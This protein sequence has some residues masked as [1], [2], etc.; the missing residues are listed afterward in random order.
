MFVLWPTGALHVNSHAV[1][2]MLEG[3]YVR[4]R[5]T[6]GETWCMFTAFSEV[7]DAPQDDPQ[8]ALQDAPQDSPQDGPQSGPHR[9]D[10]SPATS[11]D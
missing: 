10:V 8:D 2:L 3:I 11:D 6:R 9:G 1:R 5:G 7:Q 4:N